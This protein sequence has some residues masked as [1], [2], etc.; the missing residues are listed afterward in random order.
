MKKIL[1]LIILLF[2]PFYVYADS[3]DLSK[4]KIEAVSVSNNNG[5]VVE[6]ESTTQDNNIN[7]NLKMSKPG[8]SITYR[9]VI[10]NESKEDLEID[11]SNIKG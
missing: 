10:K 9:I 1:Y 2:I 11:K 4:I 7:F 3:C 6:T 5:E 8:D